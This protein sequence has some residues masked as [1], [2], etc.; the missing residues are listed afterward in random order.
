MKTYIKRKYIFVL[1]ILM[2]V[3]L[4]SCSF[5]KNETDIEYDNNE[6]IIDNKK[7]DDII[8]DENELINKI[9]VAEI[10]ADTIAN[11]DKKDYVLEYTGGVSKY[12]GYQFYDVDGDSID[13]LYIYRKHTGLNNNLEYIY[14]LIGGPFIYE[15]YKIEDGKAVLN[16]TGEPRGNATCDNCYLA[17][18]DGTIANVITSHSDENIIIFNQF[19]SSGIDKN[20]IIKTLHKDFAYVAGNPENDVLKINDKTVESLEYYSEINNI[21]SKVGLFNVEIKQ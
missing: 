8:S 14:R 21:L 19:G 2:C 1:T 15:S 11:I 9:D 4:S 13:E 7:I 18:M 12:I 10:Y 16:F 6:E 17:L 20:K 5:S 3:L